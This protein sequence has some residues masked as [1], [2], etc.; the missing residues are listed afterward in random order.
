VVLGSWPKILLQP[1]GFPGP[2]WPDGGLPRPDLSA[3]LQ[4][5]PRV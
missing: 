4:P 2:G 5:T 1:P 3:C